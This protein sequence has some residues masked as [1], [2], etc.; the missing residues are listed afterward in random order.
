MAQGDLYSVSSGLQEI[1]A[2]RKAEEQQALMN[3]MKER[4]LASEM[5]YRNANLKSLAEQREAAAE[6]RRMQSFNQWAQNFRMGDDL[7]TAD[8]EMI[9]YARRMGYVTDEN[10]NPTP[11]VSTGVDIAGVGEG[12]NMVAGEGSPEGDQSVRASLQPQAPEA[13]KKGVYFRGLPKEREQQRQ[14]QATAALI[15]SGALTDPKMSPIERLAM[16]QQASGSYDPSDIVRVM[17]EQAQE[18]PMNILDEATGKITPALDASG[19]PIMGRGG[20]PIITRDRPPNPSAGMQPYLYQVSDPSDPTGQKK[21]SHWLRPGEQP[22]EKNQIQLNGSPLSGVV[23]G[24]TPRGPQ[25]N[26]AQLLTPQQ[27]Q[28]LAKLRTASQNSVISGRPDDEY[29]NYID[30]L[31]ASLANRVSDPSVLTSI[32][33]VLQADNDPNQPEHANLTNEQIVARIA[34]TPGVTQQELLEF[35]TLLKAIRE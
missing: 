13:P 12:P 18:R 26:N 7:S 33:E 11:S 8:P 9:E 24:N 2:R 1:L 5:E 29:N 28:Y 32:E 6:A 17:T 15:Q 30:T 34:K 4:E 31:F 27:A 14:M 25:A 20:N 35:S 23:R 3:S 21:I 16:L 19:K 22:N 10:P